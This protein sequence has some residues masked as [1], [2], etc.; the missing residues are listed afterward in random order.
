MLLASK[1]IEMNIEEFRDFCLS[2]PLATEDMPFGDGVLTFRIHK[3]IFALV[4][5][6]GAPTKVNLKCDP[7][8]ALELR[9]TYPEITP[10]YHMNKKHWNTLLIESL[11]QDLVKELIL[12]SYHLVGTP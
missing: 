5:L 8:R 6:A 2:L 3:K 1:T 12:H 9:E 11:S 4:S 7:Q 10:G